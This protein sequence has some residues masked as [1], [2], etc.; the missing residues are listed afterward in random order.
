[1][2]L[3][4]A[5]VRPIK[6]DIEQT[7]TNH[8]RLI[9]LAVSNGAE[10]V[11]FPELSLTGYEPELASELATTPDD[12]RFDIFQQ[13]SDTRQITIGVG[14]PIKGEAGIWI[15]LVLFQPQQARHLYSKKYLHADEEPFFVSGKS[16]VTALGP[17]ARIALAICYE[18]SV[19]EHSENAFKNGAKVY[20]TSVAKSASGMEKAGETLSAIARNYAMTVLIANSVGFCD[21]FESAGKTAIWNNQGQLVGQLDDTEEGIVLIDTDTQEVIERTL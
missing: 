15:S 13:I 1:M 18:L 20:I 7:I 12:R 8:Q 21:T 2:K 19:P 4:V 5:Q 6:G 10:I 14:V 17:E 16:T 9:D 3:C 11:I